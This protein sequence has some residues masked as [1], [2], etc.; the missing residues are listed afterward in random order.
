[1]TLNH[2]RFSESC[3]RRRFNK[4]HRRLAS[5][6]SISRT[7]GVAYHAGVAHA[8]AT[9]DWSGGIKAARTAFDKEVEPLR[10][11]LLPQELYVLEDNWEVTELMVKLYEKH[12]EGEDVQIV[13]PECEFNVPLTP[14]HHHCIWKHWMDRETKEEHW[15]PPPPEMI[16]AGRVMSPHGQNNI[17]CPCWTQH[18]VVGRIDG[19]WRWKTQ[20]WIN[21]HKSTALAPENFWAQWNLNY[22]PRIY[23]YG[24]EKALGIR[25][26]GFIINAI[27]K[28]SEGQVSAWNAKRKYGPPQ[29]PKDYLKYGREAY[30]FTDED[31]ERTRRE[32]VQLAEEWEWRITQGAFPLAPPPQP[33]CRMYNKACEFTALCTNHDSTETLAGYSERDTYDYVEKELFQ[34][35]PST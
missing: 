20:L 10:S 3:W 27:F 35:A 14:H 16:L 19:I 8:L 25:P 7:D 5:G 23:A 22:Q 13:Q 1:M 2:T 26:R 9:K 30:P 18:R 32:F 15:T 6:H 34:I 29:S 17:N 21:D 11:T 31:V 33:A 24:V 4:F 28:P 12:F